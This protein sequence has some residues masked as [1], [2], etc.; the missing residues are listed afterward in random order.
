MSFGATLRDW[1]TRRRHSQM[2]LALEADISTRHLCYLETGKSGPSREMVVR[3]SEALDIPRADRNALLTAAGFAPAY[4]ER[5]WNS[6]DLSAVREAVTLML[7]NHDPYPAFALDRHWT[8]L[9]LNASANRLVGALGLSAGK[10][11][12]NAIVGDSPLVSAI[13]N[14]DE[15]RAHMRTRLQAES[16]KYGGDPIL[17][18][19]R[20]KLGGEHAPRRLEPAVIPVI[21]GLGEMQLSLFTVLAH[22]S[23][24]EDIAIADMKVELMFPAD[25]ATQQILESLS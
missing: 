5:Q 12:L 9:Q 6:D 17:D 2:S 22:F 4:A 3:L 25:E 21:F 11:M 8:L 10:S 23:S 18:A 24:V 7:D 1:R 19:A 20:D 14:I 16:A 13:Q 15:V